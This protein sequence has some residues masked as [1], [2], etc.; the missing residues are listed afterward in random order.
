MVCYRLPIKVEWKS[1]MVGK[2]LFLAAMIVLGM[3]TTPAVGQSVYG[4]D[5]EEFVKAVRERDGDKAL[6]LLRDR[7]TVLNARDAKGDTGLIVAISQR[8]PTWAGYLLNQGADL[9]LAARNGDTPLLAAARAGFL[10]GAQWLVEM[11]AKIDAANRMGETPLII[12]VQQR[13]VPIIKLL[14][15]AGANPDKTDSAQGYSA[16]DY[17]K[18]D[19]RGGEILRLIEAMKP[20]PATAAT[21]R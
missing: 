8:D 19:N 10:E 15:A 20:K 6:Q 14:L 9:D 1:A 16:R 12:A 2:R 18:R 11:H 17:A 7:P 5:G 21:S 4:S 3:Q 13:Q